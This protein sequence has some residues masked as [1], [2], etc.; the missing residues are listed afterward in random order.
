M[1]LASFKL[2]NQSVGPSRQ[3]INIYKR[4]PNITK[5]INKVNCFMLSK[6]QL[7][8]IRTR[9]AK[10]GSSRFWH[11]AIINALCVLVLNRN[12]AP[13][14]EI[15]NLSG[16]QALGEPE[17]NDYYS[18][19]LLE[20]PRIF[21]ISIIKIISFTAQISD[22]AAVSILG[23]VITIVGLPI[24]YLTIQKCRQ[25]QVEV[26]LTKLT[27]GIFVIICLILNSSIVHKFEVNGFYMNP[28]NMGATSAN[29]SFLFLTLGFL[30]KRKAI[31]VTMIVMALLIHI[32]TGIFLV[33][34]L[35]IVK[36]SKSKLHK[37]IKQ[38]KALLMVALFT[39]V[40]LINSFVIKANL[41]GWY[42]YINNRASNHYIVTTENPL[43]YRWV[44]YLTILILIV[45]NI[46]IDRI[47]KKIVI[48]ILVLLACINSQVAY[49]NYAIPFVVVAV[50]VLLSSALQRR[51][52]VLLLLQWILFLLQTFAIQTISITSSLFIPGTRFTSIL[53]LT[54]IML[55]AIELGQIPIAS[56]KVLE[57]Q[58]KTTNGIQLSLK[59]FTL[60]IAIVIGFSHSMNAYQSI[61]RAVEN[62][63]SFQVSKEKQY[64]PIGI[65]TVG[66]R[67]FGN[68]NI[69]VDEY[70]FWTDLNEYAHRS[71]FKTDLIESI[72]NFQFNQTQANELKS[73]YKINERIILYITREYGD[74]FSIKNCEIHNQYY[75][76]D[77]W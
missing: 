4:P 58:H 3:E 51:L 55:L 29:I 37:F 17:I 25:N 71:K 68:M 46:H 66:L 44:L 56:K 30:A 63:I 14:P 48:F 2:R 36:D 62:R 54:L 34:V 61:Q 31:R 74:E 72:E 67:E 47:N 10:S 40:G 27:N 60:V 49:V 65:D 43:Q 18:S 45:L 21:T 13:W 20:S 15:D 23:S 77:L 50:L 28:L 12:K 19:S 57:I 41:E 38:Y 69:F 33:L 5:G 7:F 53:M 70:P 11:L 8:N 76:C 24:F 64:L 6:K 26:K 52:V 16:L 59:I 42:Y 22:L 35:L 1:Q 75:T 39:S 73:K 9:F 32:S